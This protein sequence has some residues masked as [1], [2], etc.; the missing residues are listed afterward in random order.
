LQKE[1]HSFSR[2]IFSCRKIFLFSP[3][4]PLTM[5][6]HPLQEPHIYDL[7]AAS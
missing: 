5:K 7:S 1:L 4:S 3:C 2:A 6:L